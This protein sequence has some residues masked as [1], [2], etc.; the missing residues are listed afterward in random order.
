M[1]TGTSKT[2]NTIN[3]G[4][5]VSITAK[6]VS[7]TS[8]GSKAS[9]TAQAPLDASTISIQANDANAVEQPSDAA[10]TAV[11]F[12]GNYYGAAGDDITVLG[13]VTAISG[14]GV[15]AVLTVKLVS[16]LNS[17]TTAAGNCTSD[18]V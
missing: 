1:A 11:S 3:V 6:V 12:G 5:H 8:S 15:N 18:N 17:I 9:V 2:G 13:L 7:Y 14:S 16:S 4:D 10:H